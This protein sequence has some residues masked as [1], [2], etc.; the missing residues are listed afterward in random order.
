MCDHFF[1]H[2]KVY[3]DDFDK[4]FKRKF[5]EFDN[6]LFGISQEFYESNS[7]KELERE[8]DNNTLNNLYH[9]DLEQ[10][11]NYKLNNDNFYYIFGEINNKDFKIDNGIVIN[12]DKYISYIKDVMK[13]NTF[14]LDRKAHAHELIKIFFE[15][16]V[17]DSI[18]IYIKGAYLFDKFILIN[19]KHISIANLI[20]NNNKGL[21]YLNVIV[22][23]G[24]DWKSNK[25]FVEKKNILEKEFINKFKSIDS[26][27]NI[28]NNERY[29]E[30]IIVTDKFYIRAGHLFDYLEKLLNNPKTTP[31]AYEDTPILPLLSQENLTSFKRLLL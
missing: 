5:N 20:K 11:K 24:K 3:G 12:S 18:F 29:R 13:S 19:D 26:N 16:F 23:F 27:F 17:N 4:D 15:S 31:Y 7:Y 25:T 28:Y 6:N 1:I 14:R 21:K 10:I 22:G 9:S 30:R 8:W 2:F